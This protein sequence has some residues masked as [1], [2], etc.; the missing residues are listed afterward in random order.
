MR[1]AGV[2]VHTCSGVFLILL[3]PNLRAFT[4]FGRG[5][6]HKLSLSVSDNKNV[7]RLQGVD[8]D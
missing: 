5:S 7:Q 1:D 2:P 3:F 6:N 8:F 4:R